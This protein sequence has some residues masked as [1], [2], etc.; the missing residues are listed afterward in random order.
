MK[1]VL[2]PQFPRVFSPVDLHGCRLDAAI[3]LFVR[4]AHKESI[5][6][7]LLDIEKLEVLLLVVLETNVGELLCLTET[8]QLIMKDGAG[9]EELGVSLDMKSL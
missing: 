7:L 1:S 5:F 9:G 3:S 6:G 2:V 4:V 8:R